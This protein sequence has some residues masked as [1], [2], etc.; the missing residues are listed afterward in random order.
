[1]LVTP[2]QVVRMIGAVAT[3]Y[4]VNPRMLMNEPIVQEPLKISP[5]THQFLKEAMHMSALEGTLQRLKMKDVEVWGKTGT[6]Q[7][8]NLRKEKFTHDQ[9]EHGWAVG[10]F[11]YRDERPFV[12]VSFVEHVGSSRPAISHVQNFLKGY[13]RLQETHETSYHGEQALPIFTEAAQDVIVSTT[14]QSGG[15]TTDNTVNERVLS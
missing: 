13:R 1:M 10:Y 15:Q 7:T 12:F 14:Q 9:L 4:L 8:S 2:M 5:S 6:A 11:R 3:G